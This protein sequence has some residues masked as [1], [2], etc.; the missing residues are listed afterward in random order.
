VRIKQGTG[1]AAEQVWT[2]WKTEK[3]LAP[4]GNGNIRK[5]AE[6]KKEGNKERGNERNK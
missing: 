6:G 1:R 5:R 2:F 3:P 4:H